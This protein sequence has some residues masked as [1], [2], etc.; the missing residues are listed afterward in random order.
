MEINDKKEFTPFCSKCYVL[1]ESTKIQYCTTCTKL[2][3]KNIKFK[4]DISEKNL[5]ELVGY[6]FRLNKRNYLINS[7][8]IYFICHYWAMIYQ[9]PHSYWAKPM[10]VQIV[11]MK[12]D[13]E[14][15]IKILR[16]TKIYQPLINTMLK[17]NKIKE[18]LKNDEK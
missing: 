3:Y 2:L 17:Y 8:D 11:N 10:H 14:E 13:I 16:G 6:I 12:N 15:Y 1:K 18:G 9:F 7:I 4:D 5:L